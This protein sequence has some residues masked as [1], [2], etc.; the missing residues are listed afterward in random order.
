MLLHALPSACRSAWPKWFHGPDADTCAPT[1]CL[2][3]L[4]NAPSLVLHQQLLCRVVDRCIP[5]CQGLCLPGWPQEVPRYQ[6]QSGNYDMLYAQPCIY[7]LIKQ[8]SDLLSQRHM[9]R[10]AGLLL[11]LTTIF[12]YTSCGCAIQHA[13]PSLSHMLATS[14][15]MH[16]VL[17]QQWWCR[18]LGR[19]TKRHLNG[20]GRLSPPS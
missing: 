3:R 2:G 13:M 20:W 12:L 11:N 1:P 14:S 18:K 9:Y 6:V 8:I 19:G 15:K 4:C 10:P 17:Q 16:L 5:R 7:P